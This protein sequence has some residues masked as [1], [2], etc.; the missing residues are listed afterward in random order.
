MD[1]I[2]MYVVTYNTGDADDWEVT[3]AK[4]KTEAETKVSSTYKNDYGVELFHVEA[5]QMLE[6]DGYKINLVKKS[7]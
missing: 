3:T 2:K 5:Y 6:V 4:T 7:S 1:E